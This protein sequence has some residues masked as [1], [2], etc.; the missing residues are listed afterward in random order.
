MYP[1]NMLNVFPNGDILYDPHQ[2]ETSGMLAKLKNAV[3]KDRTWFAKGRPFYVE[4]DN[5]FARPF[6]DPTFW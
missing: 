2:R 6:G 1:T 3:A 5:I 4:K